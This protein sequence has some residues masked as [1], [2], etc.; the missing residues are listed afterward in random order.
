[1]D[2][3]CL[4][5]DRDYVYHRYTGKRKSSTVCASRVDFASSI[6]CSTQHPVS[7]LRGSGCGE[8]TCCYG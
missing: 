6:G 7:L 4:K 2:S 5:Y 8:P 1:M 3:L